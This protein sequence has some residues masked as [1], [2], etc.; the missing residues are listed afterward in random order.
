[1][2]RPQAPIFARTVTQRMSRATA[3]TLATCAMGA[4][5]ALAVVPFVMVLIELG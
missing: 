5:V 3:R 1:M 4:W 2:D